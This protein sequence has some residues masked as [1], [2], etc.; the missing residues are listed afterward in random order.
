MSLDSPASKTEA[1]SDTEA[2]QS[3][4][5]RNQGTG[6]KAVIDDYP[7][8]GLQ[9]WAVVFGSFLSIFMTQGAIAAFGVYEDYYTRIFLP[10]KTPSEIAW[11]G[12][13]QLF[14]T[15]SLGLFSGKLFDEGYIRHLMFIGSLIYLF[16]YFMLSLAKPNHYYQVFL[17]QGLGVGLGMGLLYIPSISICFHY[18]KRKR[19]MVSGIASIGGSIGG[20]VQTIGLNHLFNGRVGFAWGVRIYGFIMLAMAIISNLLIRP[21]LP[22]RKL[23]TDG[24]PPPNVRKVVM[25]IPFLL[26]IFSSNLIFF[27]VYFPYFYVQLFAILHGI[28][29]NLSFYTITI[30]TGANMFGRVAWGILGDKYG[31]VNAISTTS[32]LTAVV[33]F[34]MIKATEV[35]GLIPFIIFYGFFSGGF[36][37]TIGPTTAAYVES[38]S[39]F[40]FAIGYAS[41]LESFFVL[42][43]EPIAGALLDAPQYKWNRSIIFSNVMILGGV[44]LVL[45][46]RS[47]LVKRTGRGWKT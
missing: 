39:D 33:G 13:M 36:F 4:T 28:S 19:A 22:P 12:S 41:F 5:L 30:M 16:S 35:K 20:I 43:A 24:T 47:M 17:A 26:A 38:I 34:T 40:G 8:G 27:G 32:A 1:V 15:F 21:R 25:D 11:I 14:L 37:S 46:S 18:F 6:T 29:T 42:T 3:P 31:I 23:R 44:G 9:A 7:E 2:V 10:E 45:I